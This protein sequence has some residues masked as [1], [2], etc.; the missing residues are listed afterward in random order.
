MPCTGYFTA[1]AA[2]VRTDV[3]LPSSAGHWHRTQSCNERADTTSRRLRRPTETAIKCKGGRRSSHQSASCQE[4]GTAP[5]CANAHL[6]ATLQQTAA[7]KVSPTETVTHSSGYD[8]VPWCNLARWPNGG[9]AP[10]CTAKVRAQG[11]QANIAE[12]LL[13]VWLNIGV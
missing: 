6:Q 7:N 9:S 2:Y 3:V 10:T 5:T 4:F 1:L 11:N 8:G 13:H 12:L